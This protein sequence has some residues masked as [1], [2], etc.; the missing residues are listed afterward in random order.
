MSEREGGEIETERERESQQQVCLHLRFISVS[1]VITV[2]LNRY[3]SH[4]TPLPAVSSSRLSAVQYW[5]VS[6][7]SKSFNTGPCDMMLPDKLVEAW[8]IMEYHGMTEIC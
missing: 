8:H 7:W 3:E 2:A 5:S 4:M 1:C 6:V